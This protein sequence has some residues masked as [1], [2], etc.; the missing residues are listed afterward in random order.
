MSVAAKRLRKEWNALDLKNDGS[1]VYIMP[2]S[3]LTI[4]NWK[5]RISAP[6]DSF[7]KGFDFDLA[8]NV[9]EN[10]PLRPP[11]IR[12]VTKVFHPNVNFSTGEICLDIL[13]ESWSPAWDLLSAC[14]A[15]VALLGDPEPSR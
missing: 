3:D 14:R 4:M 10:Y 1:I 7:Y 9:P 11:E 12:F 6:K 13:K 2:D 15:I 8:I 5:C